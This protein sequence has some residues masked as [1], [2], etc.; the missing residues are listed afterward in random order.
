MK[1]FYVDNFLN[2]EDFLELSNLCIEK[3]NSFSNLDYAD[4]Y[5][6]YGDFFSLPE[7]IE[8]V[9]VKKARNFFNIQDLHITYVQI[10]KYTIVNGNKPKLLSHTDQLPSTHI[11]DLCIDTSLNDWGLL[12]KDTLFKDKPNGAICLYGNEEIHSR[13]EYTSN[14][15]EDYSI[16]LFL[17]FAPSD[18]WFFKGDYKKAL[19]YSKVSPI[20]YSKN[21]ND[22]SLDQK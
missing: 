16:Q 14:N 10:V 22:I 9:I 2:K 3:S 18:H 13:P 6:R 20:M 1:T 5:G 12:V 4:G 21:N 19:K 8:N 15:V 17:N 7:N 11:I